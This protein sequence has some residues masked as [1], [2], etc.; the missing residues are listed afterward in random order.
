MSVS[1]LQKLSTLTP[2]IELLGGYQDKA[3]N[4]LQKQMHSERPKLESNTE[5]IADKDGLQRR[6]TRLSV[7]ILAHGN[8]ESI[9]IYPS[10]QGM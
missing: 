6:S 1:S 8:G 4:N 10:K 2:G 5:G 7:R 9:Y 3:W